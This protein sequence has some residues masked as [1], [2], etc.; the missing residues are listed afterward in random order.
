M[1]SSIRRPLLA[2]APVAG[3]LIIVLA[4]MLLTMSPAQSVTPD[5]PEQISDQQDIRLDA[6][7]AATLEFAD[8]DNIQSCLSATPIVMFTPVR[9]ISG[10]NSPVDVQAGQNTACTIRVTVLD[11]NNQPIRS[12]TVRLAYFAAVKG[13]YDF[14]PAVTADA[15]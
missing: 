8:G 2:I 15:S 7:G 11:K 3:A 12:Q 14:D 5:L 4:G 1:Q 6:S 13:S 9:N 10:G